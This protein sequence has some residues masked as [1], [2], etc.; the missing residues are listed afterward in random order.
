MRLYFLL[1]LIFFSVK[2]F[3]QDSTI[4]LSDFEKF[5][6]QNGKVLKTEFKRIGIAGS[7]MVAKVKTTDIFSGQSASAI[8]I[9][10]DRSNIQS[11]INPK[12]LYIDV[13][14]VDSIAFALTYFIKELE[15]QD[16]TTYLQYSFISSKDVQV[17]CRYH[18][19][20]NNW[21]FE[22]DKIYRYLRT[23][24]AGSSINFNKKRAAEL[25]DLLIRAKDLEMLE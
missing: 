15:K 6:S 16:P 1:S 18:S 9:D 23:H 20:S 5:S 13:K 14:D 10:Y 8:I 22:I 21:Q 3:A 19:F 2:T 11:L 24:V 17:S 7:Y 12:T 25:A 4:I